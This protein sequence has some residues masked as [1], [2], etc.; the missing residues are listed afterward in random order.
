ME[1][2]ILI[3][4]DIHLCHKDWNGVPNAERVAM[5]VEDVLAEYRRRPFEALLLLG[6]YSLDHWA[7]EIQGCYLNDGFS[8]TEKFVKEY[9]SRL[10]VLPIEIRM[11]AGNH[12]QFG[13]ENW[14][15]ITGHSRV[16]EYLCGGVRFL[17]LD[18]FAGNLDPTEHSDGTYTGADVAAIRRALAAHPDEKFVLCAH[19]FAPDRESEEFKQLMREE[20]RLLCL[21]GGHVHRSRVIP[22]GEEFGNKLLLYTG[23]FS[24]T[25]PKH[26]TVPDSMWGFREVVLTEHTLDTAYLTPAHDVFVDGKP[27]SHPAGT[28]DA[29]HVAF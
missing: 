14:R 8:Y 23:Q 12:E 6:D 15:R 17:L 19:H 10:Q 1:R 27:Y 3:A 11:I 24:Y 21:F 29:A 13:E 5:F 9:L 4:S 26:E 28:Q 25:G 18:T 2:R 20:P 16:E 22:L 7:W